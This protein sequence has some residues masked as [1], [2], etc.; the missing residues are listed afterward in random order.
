MSKLMSMH[1]KKEG[2]SSLKNENIRLRAQCKGV[3][4][5]R[6]QGQVSSQATTS[7]IKGKE[8]MSQK[9]KYGRF[10]HAYRTLNQTHICLQTRKLRACTVVLIS[11]IIIDQVEASPQIPLRVIHDHLQKTYQVG[12]SMDKVFRAKDLARKHVTG[13]YTK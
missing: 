6:N 1:L 13:D 12:V 11:N 9:V 7:K 8:V 4:P 3:V 5:L 2:I 10:I